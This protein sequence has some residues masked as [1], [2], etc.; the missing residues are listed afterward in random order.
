MF[1]FFQIDLFAIDKVRPVNRHPHRHR[2][3][4]EDIDGFAAVK[5]SFLCRNSRIHNECDLK[6]GFFF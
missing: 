1:F 2:G 5:E 6:M 3:E 4:R